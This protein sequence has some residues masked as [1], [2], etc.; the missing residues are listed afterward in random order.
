VN[1]VASLFDAMKR[2]SLFASAL[3]SGFAFIFSCAGQIQFASDFRTPMGA[4]ADSQTPIPLAPCADAMM[5]FE[6]RVQAIFANHDLDGIKDLYQTNSVTAADM[7]RELALWQPLFA[8]PADAKVSLFYKE[9]EGLPPTAL[10]VWTGIARGLTTHKVT[11]LVHVQNGAGTASV[12]PLIKIDGRLWVVPSDKRQTGSYCKPI[13][14][15]G[16]RQPLGPVTNG[17]QVTTGSHH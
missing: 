5:D 12:F 1:E 16:G 15:A 6:T 4:D 17:M 14:A 10:Q 3:L 11:H 2:T 7:Q 8:Q 13:S 9:F